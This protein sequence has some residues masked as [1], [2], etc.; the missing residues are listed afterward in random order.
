MYLDT[1][2]MTFDD[3][4]G[5]PQPQPGADVFLRSEERLEDVLQMAGI[6]ARSVILDADLNG[7]A[8]RRRS[9]TKLRA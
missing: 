1:A 6:D 2:A 7:G 5:D 8:I 3:L 9:C 4:L